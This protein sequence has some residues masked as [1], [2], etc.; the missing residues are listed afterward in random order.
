MT[1]IDKT[2]IQFAKNGSIYLNTDDGLKLIEKA[3]LPRE[4]ESLKTLTE[5]EVKK[6]ENVTPEGYSITSLFSIAAK[7]WVMSESDTE[8]KINFK[9][10]GFS[11]GKEIG[12]REFKVDRP[13]RIIKAFAHK[14]KI[15][16]LDLRGNACV[17]DLDLNKVSASEEHCTD[18]FVTASSY[19]TQ[20]IVKD[21]KSGDIR[22]QVLR[23]DHGDEHDGL[24]SVEEEGFKMTN[25]IAE[26][27][28]VP[29]FFER[30]HCTMGLMLLVNGGSIYIRSK[31]TAKWKK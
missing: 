19:F 16:T 1:R 21:I 31:A 25:A 6:S 8:N 10:M 27:A 11:T 20:R 14:T 23:Y 2:Q 28:Y 12:E 7:T 26:Q 13:Y 3:S 24:L 22:Y 9:R 4:Q 29:S 18:I 30:C 15:Y 5:E 17:I